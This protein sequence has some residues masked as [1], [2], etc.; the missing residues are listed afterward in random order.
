M[1]F[2]GLKGDDRA[3]FHVVDQAGIDHNLPGDFPLGISQDHLAFTILK[4]RQSVF[5]QKLEIEANM[6]GFGVVVFHLG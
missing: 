6:A 3:L 2:V 1:K 4:N 5:V